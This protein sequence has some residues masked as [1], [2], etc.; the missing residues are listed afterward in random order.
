MNGVTKSCEKVI[1]REANRSSDHR[2]PALQAIEGSDC[3]ALRTND[4]RA[5][6]FPSLR[7]GIG[8]GAASLNAR[9]RASVAERN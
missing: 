6:A 7:G 3:E 9:R 2:P 5:E 1:E 8:S 4:F